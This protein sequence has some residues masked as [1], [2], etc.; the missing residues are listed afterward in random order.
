MLY[1]RHVRRAGNC[2]RDRNGAVRHNGAVMIR[3]LDG[4]GEVL[5]DARGARR[6]GRE[7]RVGA[8]IESEVSLTASPAWMR[9]GLLA[10]GMILPR[11]PGFF[12]GS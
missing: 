7:L 6:V 9:H 8:R 3:R 4:R 2:R 5:L 11:P 10:P 1:G 12:I